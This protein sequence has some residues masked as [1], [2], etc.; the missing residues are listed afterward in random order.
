MTKF[1][2]VSEFIDASEKM[3]VLPMPDS[4]SENRE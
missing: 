4:E 1:E 3:Y 2:G